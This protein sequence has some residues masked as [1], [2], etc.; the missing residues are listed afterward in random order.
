MDK[1][2]SRGKSKRA[3]N[4]AE[5]A[6]LIETVTA[7][8]VQMRD[9]SKLTVQSDTKITH[10][11]RESKEREGCSKCRHIQPSQLLAC[12]QPDKLSYTLIYMYYVGRGGSEV[13]SLIVDR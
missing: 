12:A 7:K 6:Q 4:S 8:Q 11:G 13:A 2:G 1:G 5:L 9:K 10:D 3:S